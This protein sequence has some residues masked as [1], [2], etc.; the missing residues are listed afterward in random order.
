[1]RRRP[2]L[3]WR[4]K[5]MPKRVQ[6]ST[7]LA[8]ERYSSRPSAS[9]ASSRSAGSRVVLVSITP[10]QVLVSSCHKGPQRD[11]RSRSSEGADAAVHHEGAAGDEGVGGEEGEAVAGLRLGMA[12]A[13]ERSLLNELL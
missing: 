11:P 6:C 4:S 3:V 2:A 12:V 5:S 10:A 1:M 9:A 13:A 8:T 7:C